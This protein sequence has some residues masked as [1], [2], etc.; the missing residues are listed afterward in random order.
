M[1]APFYQPTPSPSSGD[2]GRG[3]RM[4][5]LAIDVV[6]LFACYD[7]AAGR[8][9]PHQVAAWLDQRGLVPDDAA[10]RILWPSAG[11][12]FGHAV[13]NGGSHAAQPLTLLTTYYHCHCGLHQLVIEP[14]AI[15]E[16][17]SAVLSHE[18]DEHGGLT[19]VES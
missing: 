5:A 12:S 15:A 11:V 19:E 10:E 14:T 1:T 13:V 16:V 7:L 3:N 4:F 9:A 18:M 8:P 6:G 17:V 2:R